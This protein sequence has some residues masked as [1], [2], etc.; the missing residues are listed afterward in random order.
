MVSVSKSEVHPFRC[1]ICIYAVISLTTGSNAMLRP[2]RSESAGHFKELVSIPEWSI[3][4]PCRTASSG[5]GRTF[6]RLFA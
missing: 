6:G 1:S 4:I 3:S 5:S 2:R